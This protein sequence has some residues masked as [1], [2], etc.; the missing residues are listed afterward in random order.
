METCKK[1]NSNF[2]TTSEQEDDDVYI[3]M[4]IAPSYPLHVIAF[5]LDQKT[6]LGIGLA[7]PAMV[8]RLRAGGISN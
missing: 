7:Y 8:P 1:G 4:E 2:P 6:T 3:Y 5:I